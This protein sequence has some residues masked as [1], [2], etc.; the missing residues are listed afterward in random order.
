[1]IKKIIS[2]FTKLKCRINCCFKSECMNDND[3]IEE[4]EISYKSRRKSI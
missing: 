2:L 3:L 1:M 4:V